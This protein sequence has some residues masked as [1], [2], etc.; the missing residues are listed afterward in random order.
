M[1]SAATRVSGLI[2]LACLTAAAAPAPE[3]SSQ[4]SASVSSVSAKSVAT[5][6]T[7]SA[8][9]DHVVLKVG[10][11]NV[12][13]ADF[14]LLVADVKGDKGGGTPLNRKSLAENYASALMLSQQALVEHLDADPEVMRKLE[15]MRLQV[16]SD[17]AYARIERQAQPTS[18]EISQYY[19]AH[20]ADYDQVD[21]RRIFIWKQKEGS[22]DGNGMNPQE[23]KIRADAILHALKTGGDA[24]SLTQGSKSILDAD[25]L[26]F[27]RGELPPYM[28]QAFD[29]KVGEWSQV[30][31]TAD[32]LILFQVVKHDRTDLREVS[33]MIEKKLQAEKIRSELDALKE[34]SN[35]WMDQKYFED[36]ASSASTTTQSSRARPSREAQ[37]RISK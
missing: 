5:I 32:A 23:A 7:A 27:A 11:V 30:A 25:P 36:S 18:Q 37:A 3:S 1:N 26:S 2:L 29:M 13:E 10:S 12:T 31:T 35:V 9:P 16:L 17:A 4:T 19:A 20:L 33:P 21:I 14:D 6:P 28:S 15:M 8:S 24:K 22:P 34:K